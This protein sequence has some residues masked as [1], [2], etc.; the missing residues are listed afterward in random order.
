MSYRNN[1]KNLVDNDLI[2]MM[3]TRATRDGFPLE[4]KSTSSSYYHPNYLT[5]EVP[6]VYTYS[7]LMDDYIAFSDTQ[8]R[9]FLIN[10]NY[11]LC[12]LG[13]IDYL[14]ANDCLCIHLEVPEE[15]NELRQIFWC[16][17]SGVLI[18][19]DP[20]RQM[21][22]GTLIS[23]THYTETDWNSGTPEDRNQWDILFYNNFSSSLSTLQHVF[24]NLTIGYINSKAMG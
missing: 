5:I 18:N 10:G 19:N 7:I 17:G 1:N 15:K 16:T 3:C 6:R 24:L 23:S 22:F 21:V 9:S 4:L 13:Y 8:R 12:D 11:D 20:Q 2:Q 14:P